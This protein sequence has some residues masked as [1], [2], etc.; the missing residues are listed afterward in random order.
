[1]VNGSSE[2]HC[3]LG[4]SMGAQGGWDGIAVLSLN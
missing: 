3:G 2:E 1:M 4:S